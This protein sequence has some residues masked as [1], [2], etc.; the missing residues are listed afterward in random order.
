M[1]VKFMP[2][3]LLY[4]FVQPCLLVFGCERRILYLVSHGFDGFGRGRES[5]LVI[6]VVKLVVT[7]RMVPHQPW[8]L[9]LRRW[10]FGKKNVVDRAF[11]PSWL[12]YYTDKQGKLNTAFENMSDRKLPGTVGCKISHNIMLHNVEFSRLVE[13]GKSGSAM[14]LTICEWQ[15]RAGC[16]V[17]ENRE[18]E[19]RRR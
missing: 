13:P 8:K 9:A 10:Q 3:Q 17:T 11:Q 2:W 7:W 14:R 12:N 4:T 19:A 1:S 16:W 5:R 6:R 15:Y 18:R